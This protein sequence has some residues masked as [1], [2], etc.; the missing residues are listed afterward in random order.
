MANEI[1]E[2]DT[3]D[4]V[5]EDDDDAVFPEDDDAVVREDDPADI[6]VLPRGAVEQPDGSVTITLD[7][8]VTIAFQNSR[9]TR[10]ET[11]STL[12]FYRLTGKDLT[13]ITNAAER[14]RERVAFA[15]ALRKNKA[16]TNGIFDRMDAADIAR[17]S[18]VLE[19]FLGSGPTTGRS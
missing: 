15:L 5:I 10:R 19:Y 14:V 11:V 9:G 12:Q 3:T 7:R 8:P 16:A 18:R 2:I 6:P 4:V 17:A 1:R 13:E